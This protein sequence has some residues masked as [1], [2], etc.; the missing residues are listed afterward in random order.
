MF[1][2]YLAVRLTGLRADGLYDR[3]GRLFEAVASSLETV[4]G[5]VL[6]APHRVTDPNASLPDGLRPFDVFLLDKLYVT[7]S[8]VV[9][10]CLDLPSFGVGA[11]LQMACDF[12]VPIVS[13][14]YTHATVA[15][16]RLILGMPA[17][18]HGPSEDARLIRYAPTDSGEIVLLRTLRDEVAQVISTRK[19]PML[20][21]PR[22][23]QSVTS[24]LSERMVGQHISI[25]E[26]AAAAGVPAG[27]IA[28][29]GMA[30]EPFR[31]WMRTMAMAKVLTLSPEAVDEDRVLLP[32]LGTTLKIASALDARREV[33]L[34]LGM[35]GADEAQN[36]QR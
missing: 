8:D 28:L 5:L 18:T 31:G 30:G 32:S 19:R 3:Y 13:F 22:P 25:R 15:P 17:L 35:G 4:P 23:S 16:S 12:G 26:L 9:I 20:S 2:G 1:H 34:L 14:Y 21:R 10:A 11:E 24:V 27:T 33:C 36:V 7:H 29:I 6:H